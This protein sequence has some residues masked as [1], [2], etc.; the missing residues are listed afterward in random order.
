MPK[1]V[2]HRKDVGGRPTK[3][4][5]ELVSKLTEIFHIDWTIYE[6]CSNACISQDTY[7]NRLK[8]KKGFS[9]EM[10]A[11]QNFPFILARKTINKVIKEW[12]WKLAMEYVRRRDKRY[13]EKIEQELVVKNDY[14]D[15]TTEELKKMLKKN[16]GLV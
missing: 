7:Y 10:S 13:K 8:S 15:K 9:E 6:A 16:N 3:F 1:G 4:S 2:Y 14:K 11:A 5:K 12:D